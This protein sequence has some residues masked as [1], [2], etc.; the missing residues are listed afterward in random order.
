[1]RTECAVRRA[2]EAGN[3]PMQRINLGASTLESS[4]L[5][6][7]CMRIAGDNSAAERERGKQAIQ[8][9]I[10]CG[11]NHFDHADI[12]GGGAC[13]ELFGEVLR[14]S[15]GLRGDII[16]TSK[17]GIR[18]DDSP[19]SGDP[20]RYDF[21]S[22]YILASVDGSLERLGVETIDFYH[23]HS[24]RWSDYRRMSGR[25]KPLERF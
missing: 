23:L 8:A 18:L 11:Y 16:L 15:P 2:I 7:G 14:E 22:D 21:S 20:K 4:R 5:V 9:A 6:Y 19:L 25:G 3:R 12:Y 10:E 24:I 17:C 1:M 13:E